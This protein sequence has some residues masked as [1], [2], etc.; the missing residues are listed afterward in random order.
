M[1]M[2]TQKNVACLLSFFL[3]LYLP[4]KLNAVGPCIYDL[5][6][7]GI[8]DLTSVGRTDGTPMWKNIPPEKY[9]AHGNYF[10]HLL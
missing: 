10:N 3:V 9:D 6:P 1:R 7:K 5:S 4:N 2:N 8:I